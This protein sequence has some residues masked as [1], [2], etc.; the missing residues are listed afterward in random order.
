MRTARLLTG[1]L[2]HIVTS[3]NLGRKGEKP[4]LKPLK[5]CCLPQREQEEIQKRSPKLF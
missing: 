1:S 5:A 2:Y 3:N 4:L